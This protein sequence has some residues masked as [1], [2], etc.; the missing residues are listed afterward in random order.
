MYIYDSA[1]PGG[2]GP[3]ED[4]V[5]IATDRDAMR[6][7]RLQNLAAAAEAGG[8]NGAG[9]NVN[10]PAQPATGTAPYYA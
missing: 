1:G 4:Y 7:E 6:L 9:G 8:V 2:F 3:I 5:G 10:T